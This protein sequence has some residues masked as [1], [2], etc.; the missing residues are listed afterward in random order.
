[1]KF[2]SAILTSASGKLGG[3]VASKARGGIKYFRALV[4]PSNPQS[5]AQST[6]R[7][8]LSGLAGA[9]KSVLNNEERAA[10]TALARDDESG[11]DVFTA[12]NTLCMLGGRARVNDAPP[13][14]SLPFIA[15][16]DLSLWTFQRDGT[17]INIG[18]D[19][20][21][22]TYLTAATTT[23][24]VFVETGLQKPSRLAQQYPFRYAARQITP[25]AAHYALTFSTETFPE[26]TGIA[27]GDQ[28]WIRI[29]GV[30]SLGSVTGDIKALMTATVA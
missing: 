26:L 1:M 17:D 27:D 6:V 5:R 4:T 19:A 24:L 3:A 15:I 13:A 2:S 10:W 12:N 25:G 14:R 28:V 18:S 30:D 11:I 21:A 22:S 7:A 9:W 8:I 23:L 20:N 29:V 16:P